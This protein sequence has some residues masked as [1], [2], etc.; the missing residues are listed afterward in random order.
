M[1]PNST[2]W[3]LVSIETMRHSMRT[4]R[5]HVVT[6][7]QWLRDSWVDPVG[8]TTALAAG[9][10]HASGASLRSTPGARL[11]LFY[12]LLGRHSHSLAPAL[13]WRTGDGELRQ[14]SYRDLCAKAEQRGQA[15]R[16]LGVD[17]GATV[18]VVREL[19][20]ELAI[21]VGAALYVGATVSVWEPTG[22]GLLSQRLAAL[23]APFVD[24]AELMG[25][26]LEAL[27]ARWLGLGELAGQST[28]G[29][30]ATYPSGAL[31]LC[32]FDS[33]LSPQHAPRWVPADAL[34]AG[35]LRDAALTLRLSR[36]DVVTAPGWPLES[37]GVHLLLAAW[38]AGGCY[39]SLG[40]DEVRRAPSLLSAGNFRAV[41]VCRELREQL[42]L[43]PRA[44]GQSWMGWFRDPAQTRGLDR[45]QAFVSACELDGSYASNV[46][47][48]SGV[49]GAA[50]WS[51]E[52]RGFVHGEA[53]PAAGIQWRTV[54]FHD[55]DAE[56]VFGH[57]RLSLALQ[58]IAKNPWVATS[59][60]L[61]AQ[62]GSWFWAGNVAEGVDGHYYPLT[63]VEALL[64]Q[65][66][67]MPGVVLCL[68]ASLDDS[69]PRVDAVL[70]AGRRARGEAAAL[71]DTVRRVVSEGF[72]PR[73]LPARVEVFPLLPR[74]AEDG[75]V[76]RAWCVD[77]YLRS[78]LA[79]RAGDPIHQQ[80]A[81]IEEFV[82]EHDAI[83]PPAS[84]GKPEGGL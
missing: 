42:L 13:Q 79:R 24:A 34:F 78:V 35:A 18:C 69:P 83:R 54:D 8:F 17:A 19:G 71:R 3:E 36:G 46:G 25:E 66:L 63:A 31:A 68:V 72:G 81:A 29:R 77:A 32:A 14:I 9:T 43:Q 6:T 51:P 47:F 7:P 37:A 49:G 23:K 74:S 53:S 1:T 61:V 82:M 39:Y 65:R 59:T 58:G 40:L 73:W 57:G 70:L 62:Q 10:S 11:E 50:F 60:I 33:T 55:H 16:A 80:L 48:V 44:M 56:S 22:N 67:G 12:D 26:R 2:Q 38:M 30:P 15:W 52:R 21:S 4:D 28:Q 75:G 5:A 45:W 76:D 64:R 84:P 27:G 41:G 20:S